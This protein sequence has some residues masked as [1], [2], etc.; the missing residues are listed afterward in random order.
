ML[1]VSSIMQSKLAAAH[2]NDAAGTENQTLGIT[3]TITT[4]AGYVYRLGFDASADPGFSYEH[5]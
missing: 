4:Q 1:C 3:R 5:S 2:L